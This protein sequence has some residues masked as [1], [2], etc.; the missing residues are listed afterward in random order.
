MNR[1]LYWL[2]AL[3][4][5][6]TAAAL[7]VDVPIATFCRQAGVPGF[8]RELLSLA[9]VFGHGLGAACILLTAFVIDVGRR[10]RLPR[11][12][13]SVFG[14][15]LLADLLKLVV[16]RLRPRAL[17]VDHIWDSFIGWFPMFLQSTPQGGSSSNFKSFPSGHAVV[18]TALAI[19]LSTLYPRGRWL[20]ACFAVL[21]ALQRVES[22]AH[23][24]S[25]TLAGAAIACLFCGIC[26]DAR[27]LGRW[28]D[29][30]EDELD[31]QPLRFPGRAARM[32]AE[33]G[34]GIETDGS[35]AHDRLD[36]RAGFGPGGGR[37][38]A[39]G[40]S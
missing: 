23:Y 16:G 4:L 22:L 13:I 9:E 11:I 19:G 39:T 28:F 17:I 21:A 37:Q 38:R 33:A 30:W 14:A 15:G 6:A 31:R 26:F 25:D 7:A 20:F 3:F 27:L 36:N 34:Q 40:G 35:R 32:K 12:A 29:R 5:V 2:A 1:R 18:A 8:F 24:L 10:R